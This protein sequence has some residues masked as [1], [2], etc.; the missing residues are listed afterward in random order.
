MSHYSHPQM[1][2]HQG[3]PA[4][5]RR[6]P[7][8]DA[9]SRANTLSA[10]KE[11]EKPVQFSPLAKEKNRNKYIPDN[12]Y[13]DDPIQPPSGQD[14]IVPIYHDAN[15]SPCSA[16]ES[17]G[18]PPH[19]SH[20][21]PWQLGQTVGKGGTCRVRLVRHHLTGEV[22]VAKIIRKDVAEKTRA[23]SLA[24]LFSRAETGSLALAG[25]Y[26]MPLGLEREMVIMRLLKHP[27]IVRLYDV[28]ENRED[29]LVITHPYCI[30]IG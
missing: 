2:S 10:S 20:I 11:V 1:A 25:R 7:L 23:R 3:A 26:A 9:T 18:I 28:W 5:V 17:L 14:P 15:G 19:K 24:N 21:G 13:A 8:Q 27:N 4:P 29:M 16:R 30:G 12:E 6:A 22:M